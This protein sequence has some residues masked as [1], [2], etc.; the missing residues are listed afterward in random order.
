M[1]KSIKHSGLKKLYANGDTKGVCA[2]HVVRL[3]KRLAVLD[4]A[5]SLDDIAVHNWKLHPLGGKL[6]HQHALWVSGN[7]RL[8]FEFRGGDVYLLDYSDYH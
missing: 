7:W 3:Q 5:T 6:K 8:V 2:G 1:I 4:A